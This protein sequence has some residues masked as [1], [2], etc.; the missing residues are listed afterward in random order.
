MA[1]FRLQIS[2]LSA[3]VLCL[4]FTSTAYSDD[5]E[6][7]RFFETKIR[8]ILVKHCYECHGPDL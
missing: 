4:C 1:D 8:P 7:N 6:G 2:N 5:A 3:L